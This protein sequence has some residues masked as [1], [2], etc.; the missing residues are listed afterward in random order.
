MNLMTKKLASLTIILVLLISAFIVFNL[1]NGTRAAT[2]NTTSLKVYVAPTSVLADNNVYNCIF[3]QLLDSNGQPFRAL[4][5]TTIS[6][7][8]SLSNIGTVDPTITIFKNTT[9]ASAN[10]YTTLAPGTTTISAV[11]NRLR[12]TTSNNNHSYTIAL[13]HSNIR[14]SN[15][16]T[17]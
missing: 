12:N 6:L 7:S 11:S 9:Y 8:S 2:S 17:C 4:Q 14:I 16:L 13:S 10:F 1:N 15:N 5:D 3:V